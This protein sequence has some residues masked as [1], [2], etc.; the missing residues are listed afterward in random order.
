MLWWDEVAAERPTPRPA[1]DSDVTADVCIVGGGY[2]GLW[3][4]I[5]TKRQDPTAKVVLVEAKRVG[6]G[7][8]GRNGG[9]ATG[10]YDELPELIERFGH[11][12]ALWLAHACSTGID[13]IKRT[14]EEF[15]FD[16]HFRQHGAL[17][18]STAPAHDGVWDRAVQA[19]RATGNADKLEVLDAAEA[20]RRTGS[21]LVRC[22]ARQTD[23]AAVH[24]AR[25]VL[26]LLHAATTLGVRVYE[27]TPAIKVL[28][29]ATPCVVTPRGRVSAGHVVLATNVGLLRRRELR[30]AAVSAGS[31]I[32]ATAPLG[33]RLKQLPFRH[34]ELFGDARLL[35]HY[36]QVTRSGRLVFGRGGGYIGFMGRASASES[37]GAIW[38]RQ[39]EADLRRYFPQLADV[40]ITHRW[41][42]AVDRAPLHLPFVG[43]LDHRWNITYALGYSG[44]GVA[45]SVLMGRILSRL[46]LGQQDDY[47]TC[48][49]VSGPPAY[50]PPEPF[51]TVGGYF[52]QAAIGRV[53]RAQERGRRPGPL[54]SLGRRLLWAT[55]PRWAEPRL[56][57]SPRITPRSAVR[58]VAK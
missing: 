38:E 31:H 18:A 49:L 12:Q 37:G 53:E 11:D 3:T 40:P 23:G 56:R 8:S 54:S 20:A 33:D 58:E 32:V 30:R 35:V 34:G 1:L 39:V 9:W 27:N 16:C 29:G 46:A 6:D 41:G 24:P 51:R 52:V 36:A 50:L 47:T 57:Q 28:Q 43:A 45:P 15:N 4:A 25:L 14:A 42:G 48:A 26:G 44:N 17:W 19:C 5:E 13:E 21:P 55:T 2:T 10:W 7:A 22:A